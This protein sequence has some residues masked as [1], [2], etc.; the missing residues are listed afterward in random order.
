[1]VAVGRL[2]GPRHSRLGSLHYRVLTLSTVVASGRAD[3]RWARRKLSK[4]MMINMRSSADLEVDPVRGPGIRPAALRSTRRW[5]SGI[6][7]A[8]FAMVAFM[9]LC[10]A[11]AAL[12]PPTTVPAPALI[13]DPHYRAWLWEYEQRAYPLGY[14]PPG[15]RQKALTEIRQA[16]RS[17]QRNSV[18][19]G[20]P[21]WASIGPAPIVNGQTEPPR[22]VSGRV[23]SIAVDPTDQAHWLI[24][25]ARGGVWETKDSG[26][27]WTPKSD[28][29]PSLS[30]G[31][32]AFAP[33]NPAIMFAGTGEFEG[34]PGAGLLKSVDG[35]NSWRLLGSAQFSET[36][37]SAIRV[38]PDDANWL[39]AATAPTPFYAYGNY[40]NQFPPP[41]PAPVPGVYFSTDGGATWSRSLEGAVF[42]FI[43]DP[44]DFTNQYAAVTDPSGQSPGV[45]YRSMDGG[46]NWRPL[47]GPWGRWGSDIRA[48]LA[49]SRS[50]P[51][52]VYVCFAADSQD[53]DGIW[54]TDNAWDATPTWT[55]LPDLPQDP[56]SPEQQ[57]DYDLAISVDPVNSDVLYAGLTSLYRYDGAQ[58]TVLGGDYIPNDP[59]TAARSLHADQHALLWAGP[60]LLI[61]NDGGI[62]S[63]G[64]NGAG[65]LDFNS[66]LALTQ[67]YY[68]S[69]APG[70]QN[71]ILAGSQDNGSEVWLGTNGWTMVDYGD[72]AENAI[73]PTRPNDHWA[74]GWDGGNIDRITGAGRYF[75]QVY[76]G[77][78]DALFISPLAMSPADENT[79][80]VG[81]G[82]ELERTTDFFSAANPDWSTDFGQA[83]FS[84]AGFPPFPITALAFAPSDASGKTYAFGTENGQVWLTTTGSGHQARNIN[85]GLEIPGRYVTA[86]AFAPSDSN[87]LY[88]TLSGFDEGTPGKPGHVF[89]TLDALSGAPDWANVSPPVDLPNNAVAVDPNDPN[90][91]YVG[92]DIGVWKTAD[93]GATWTDLGPAS[94]MPNV[95]VF[96]LKIQPET[97]RVFAFTYGRG[98]FML[99]PRAAVPAITSFTPISGPVGAVVTINGAKLENATGVEFGGVEAASFNAVSTSQVTATVP[100]GAV[101]GPV[102][103]TTP[104]GTATSPDVFT[105]LAAPAIT[106]FTPAA[107]SVGTT[108]TIL[109][110][111]LAGATN[112]LFGNASTSPISSSDRSIAVAVPAGA[113]TGK[114][115]VDT[116]AG[117][118]TSPGSFTVLNSPVIAG[119]SPTSG[120]IGAKVIISGA[121][122]VNLTGVSF[123]GAPAVY[124]NDSST[125]ITAT[126]PADASSGPISVTTAAGI[127]VS[128]ADFILI[129]AP[130]ISSFAP[131]SGAGGTLVTIDGAHFTGAS[132]VAFNGAS[133]ADFRVSSD[134]QILATA[135]PAVTTGPLWIATAGGVAA[136]SASFTAMA[137][138]ANDNFAAAQSLSGSSGTVSGSNLGASK[139]PGEPNHAGNAGG[140]SVWYRWT[141]PGSGRWSFNTFG[142]GFDTLL[143]VYTGSA[144]NSLTP[145]ASNDNA[146]GTN[147]SSV[148][149][150][151]TAG[152]VYEVSVD[153]FRG[154]AG[155]GRPAPL[156]AAGA[157]V[158]NWNLASSYAPQISSFS[159]GRGPV[160][161]SVTIA[162][163]NF[164]GVSDVSFN[165]ISAQFIVNSDFQ[166]GV[167]VPSGA[168]TGPIQVIKAGTSGATSSVP[169]VVTTGP[170]NDNFA[171]A[172]PLTGSVG[173]LSGSNIGATKE[174]GEPDHAGE[175]GGASVWF[176]WTPPGNGTWRFDTLGSSFDTLLAIYTGSAVD[177]LSLVA[178]NDDSGGILTSQVSFA[179]SGGTTYYIAADGYGGATGSLVLNWALAGNLPVITSFEPATGGPG[180]SVTISGANFSGVSAVG[181]SGVNTAS[182]TTISSS[183]IVAIV[184]PGAGTGPI[185]I[186]TSNGMTQSTANFVVTVRPPVNDAF[187]NRLAIDGAVATVTGSSAGATKEPGEPDHAGNAGGASVWWT[188]TAPS[189]GT[190]TVT[191]RGSSFDTLLG[192]YTGSSVAS[193]TAV[194]AN[195]DGPNMGAASLL[196]FPAMA[197]TPY[198]LAVDGYDGVSG[199]ILLSVYPSSPS[200]VIYS[201]GF[202]SSEGYSTNSP[203]AGQGGWLSD[204]PG[205]NGVLYNAFSD[206][207]QQ[208]FVGFSSPTNGADTYVWRPLDYTPDT[209]SEPVVVFSTDLAVVDSDNNHYDA[210]DW[211]FWNNDASEQGLFYLSFDN[212]DMGIYYFLNDGS[213]RQYTG[214]DFQDGVI[215][216]LEVALDFARNRWSASLDG[217]TFVQDQPIS[218]TNNVALTLGDIDATWVQNIGPVGDNFMLFDNYSVTAQASQAP[219]IITASPS[220]TVAQGASTNL[221]VVVDTTLPVTYQWLFNGAPIAE[222]TSPILTLNDLAPSQAGDYSVIVSNSVGVV[223][224]D[225]QVFSVTNTPPLLGS[226]F[227]SPNGTFEFMLQGIPSR[228][229]ELLVSTN[230]VGWSVLGTLEDTNADGRLWLSDPFAAAFSHRF[231][232]LL[233]L[234]SAASPTRIIGLNGNVAFGDVAVGTAAQSTMTITNS[235]NAILTISGISYPSGFSGD[236]SSGAIPAGGSQSVTVTFA[237]TA[238]TTYS[239]TIAVA[240]DATSGSGDISVSGN[241][242]TYDAL[243]QWHLRNPSPVGRTLSAVTYAN[244]LFVAVGDGAILTSPDGLAW[245]RQYSDLGDWPDAITYGDGQF[246]AIGN[247]D[248][249]GVV[250]TSPD[251]IH[252]TRR[253][254]ATSAFLNGVAYGSGTFIAVGTDGALL[255]SADGLTWSP[256]TSGTSNYLEG[257]AYGAGAFVAV[258]WDDTVLRSAD[259]I[260]WTEE[261]PGTTA[262]SHDWLGVGYGNGQFVAV[263]D[264]YPN[265]GFTAAVLTSPNGSQWSV[266]N[267]ING[268]NPLE[269]VAYGD[270]LYIAVGEQ[271]TIL[272]S[273]D[274]RA[275][276][277][278]SAGGND[279]IRD[280]AYGAGRFVAVGQT[281]L[282]SMGFVLTSTDGASWTH[283]DSGSRP[284]FNGTACGLG[285][286]V[287]V[288]DAGAISTSPDG[289]LWTSRHS[290]TTNDLFGVTAG[291]TAL[292]AVGGSGTILV[293]P[294][295]TTWSAVSSGITNDINGVAFGNGLYVAV[296][297]DGPA[298]T[299]RDAFHWVQHDDDYVLT[300]DL[301]G[302]TYGHGLFVAVGGEFEDP[303][304]GVTAAGPIFT[305]PDGADWQYAYGTGLPLYGVAYGNGL[306]VAVGARAWTDP[307]GSTWTGAGTWTSPDAVSWTDQSSG[308]G[309]S[310]ITFG[311]GLFVSV[312]TSENVATASSPDGVHWTQRNTGSALNLKGI[313]YGDGTFVAAGDW[314]VVLQSSSLF[315]SATR[316]IGLNGSLSFGNVPLGATPQRTMTI[317]NSGN[318]TLTVSNI[319]YPSGF[320]GDWASGT[321]PP[322]GAQGV[323]VTFHAAVAGAYSGALTVDS[324]ATGGRASLDLSGSGAAPNVGWVPVGP[325]QV[326]GE[327]SLGGFPVPAVS[328]RVVGVAPDPSDPNLIYIA[329]AGG[330]V[331]KT[332]DGGGH[333]TPLT[334]SQITT[335]MGAI[336]VAPSNPNVIYA[337]TGEQ[338]GL[339]LPARGLGSFFFGRGIL[340]SSDGGTT[341][342]LEGNAQFDRRT[343]TRI[344]VDPADADTVYA[345]IA[346]GELDGLHDNAGVWKSTDGGANWINTTASISTTDT[347]SDLALDPSNPQ[348]LYAAVSSPAGAPA[349]G[350]YKTT[351]GGANWG[352]AGDF[353]AGGN[354]GNIKLALAPSAPQVLY[355]S[356]AA[357]TVLTNFLNFKGQPVCSGLYKMLKTTDGG[358]TWTDLPNVPNYL[359][360]QGQFNSTLAVDPSDPEIVYAGGS[361]FGYGQ[362]SGLVQS[363]DGGATWRAIDSGYDGLGT[364]GDCHAMAFDARGRLLLGDDGG[365]WRLE[366][367]ANVLWSDLNSDLN[368]IQFYG[369]AL[370]P[371]DPN[372]IYGGTQDNG[373]VKFDGAPQG[374]ELLGGDGGYTRLDPAQPTIVYGEESG[375]ALF[376][377]EDSGVNWTEILNGVS[378]DNSFPMVPYAMDPSHPARMVMGTDKVYETLDGGAHW[379]ALSAPFASGWNT[380]EVI[381]SVAVAATDTNTIYASPAGDIFAT[382]D[383]GHSWQERDLG[384][385]PAGWIQS[386]VVDPNDNLT[387]YAARAIVGGGHIF[388]TTD[389]GR[390]WTDISGNLPDL[391]ASSIALDSR[392]RPATLYVGN[393]NGVYVSQDLGAHWSRVGSGLPNAIVSGIKLNTNLNI[394]AAATYG[395][396]VWEIPLSQAVP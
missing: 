281:V 87:T 175:A 212:A 391:P 100:P 113:T 218:A 320:T 228:S 370:D 378:E 166:I 263:G 305:S 121:N 32:V 27:S 17:P 162:G 99:D 240:S 246:V 49:I 285:L 257:I 319:I 148:T 190:Y 201:T 108:V 7:L 98:A 392:T 209:N 37:L 347:F 354:L 70:N 335:V 343:T 346:P 249:S 105:V 300:A 207:G 366:D 265:G 71:L 88:V 142:S 203:L 345:A 178:S 282:G 45:L 90:T 117:S 62:W 30:I 109:G 67:F 324:D 136:S 115:R 75:V 34:Y 381:E 53:L 160:G 362:P 57:L 185:S 272:A 299:S 234:G 165:G 325:A 217:N 308:P 44:S 174:P 227:L 204:G 150:T 181:F 51:D 364:H 149:F 222:A 382:F 205:L 307:Y 215:Y 317:T 369:I 348:I 375:L 301:L 74:A 161:A 46:H 224:N 25:T 78:Q 133:A 293:S 52:T 116:H 54:K 26:A 106:S 260:H 79:V 244:G 313:A 81:D 196:S 291:D 85:A 73:S 11:P 9:E 146:P 65:L 340:K 377:S 254:I 297:A 137:A 164:T 323:A 197:G 103:L 253:T 68:G 198:Q 14:V 383:H 153:G 372:V 3:R 195:D 342:A 119:F 264:N 374:V 388:Y 33:S 344:V 327:A 395:R 357:P 193:L 245:T 107:G 358:N 15:A 169:F 294:D 210:F 283:A 387:V 223:T 208:A 274:G 128:T 24:G 8:A 321:I 111:N 91:V 20:G 40:W 31:A 155:E 330:G 356:I 66:N 353:P 373:T 127:T 200:R 102:T 6:R 159:P 252:W 216:H 220:L 42:A 309:G 104:G 262:S 147:A 48:A 239:G 390:D 225:F 241:G 298:L 29:Q 302:I 376:R 394:L 221:M 129:P 304:F 96:D 229:Y 295:G 76:S 233:L 361:A 60:R 269:A 69:P 231:Y 124:S 152:T 125:Q 368:T 243:A 232:R 140:S 188:W 56:N 242:V 114:I 12:P 213:P 251:G 389:G 39:V 393:Y 83:D 371:T 226:P 290:G 214:Q 270:G 202:R 1:M 182:F 179:A 28:D 199:N 86:L 22:P 126:V 336:A 134:T 167:I 89:K 316:R 360:F 176:R 84:S 19:W 329:T 334:D 139:E 261:R 36:S 163:V 236:W 118:V 314:G 168:S 187:A 306:F 288:G 58:W 101:T 110:A 80:I 384:G 312:G 156:P 367:P 82:Y 94:G 331:W 379:T 154:D 4:A 287:G 284:S 132:A 211:S 286:F 93:G 266:Q 326:V 322:G 171:D 138:P 315:G 172:Q 256:Q 180:T 278:R 194:A 47:G 170:A 186:T 13:N 385:A 271:G 206:S 355:A 275:W 311:D 145:I 123:D 333:W 289:V 292:V 72:G 235:G 267:S 238:A 255:T 337:G 112:V 250:L 230:L 296:G 157:F 2:G 120:G 365:I 259:G 248:K 16:R 279:E 143:A 173:T 338:T 130:T 349:N 396:G 144:V 276:N 351:D 310:A 50:N 352:R 10:R 339:Y 258:G 77:S 95:A 38:N 359:I 350:V 280:V 247:S 386:L 5:R 97:G 277:D 55:R 341:W 63:V 192:I 318:S 41:R 18:T 189:N 35:G 191:T 380:D 158:L 61:G 303:L 43:V 135:P 273:A 184:S 332:I 92:T 131:A 268:F 151:A 237:P 363:V 328:G 219:R 59:R 141:A 23:T 183:Q 21:Q 122:F 64:E 177:S